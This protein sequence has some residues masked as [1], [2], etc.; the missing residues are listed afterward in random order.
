M[1]V[2]SGQGRG[3]P[4]SQSWTVGHRRLRSL[5]PVTRPATRHWS[6]RRRRR[7]AWDEAVRAR[8]GAGHLHLAAGTAG[9]ELHVGALGDAVGG[10]KWV[11]LALS[12]PSPRVAS[13]LCSDTLAG[14]SARPRSSYADATSPPSSGS[15]RTGRPGSETTLAPLGARL[16]LAASCGR[17]R[18][19][20]CPECLLALPTEGCTIRPRDCTPG[21]LRPTPREYCARGASPKGGRA[22][23]GRGWSCDRRRARGALRSPAHRGPSHHSHARLTSSAQ[24]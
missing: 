13:G 5:P 12:R 9:G 16:E 3:S 21:P 14:P 4:T 2:V 18:G 7:L 17:S 11:D 20:R 23:S 15:A 6:V 1:S 19:V 24:R 8:L 22:R 10:E